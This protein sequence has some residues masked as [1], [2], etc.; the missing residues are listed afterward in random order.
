MSNSSI[1]TLTF[2]FDNKT[3]HILLHQI[4]EEG[5]LKRKYSGIKG[6]VGILEDMNEAALRNI[7]E[8]TGLEV[9]EVF[10]R[11]VVKTNQVETQTSVIYF[12]YE[13]SKFS[14]ELDGKIPGR[15]KW[16]D[17]LNIFNLQMESLVHRLMPNLLDGE[18]FF[19]GS[20][21]LNDQD[22]VISSNIR[23]CNSV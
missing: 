12:V 17:I 5:P 16:V 14:G 21:Q 22:E 2:I 15:L 10:L 18:S 3:D 23:I 13:S 11:G 7:K 1:Q 4:A 6:N 20:I 19:E 8:T 9:T